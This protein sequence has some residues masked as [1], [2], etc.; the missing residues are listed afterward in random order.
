MYRLQ[1]KASS[2]IEHTSYQAV[3]NYYITELLIKKCV[4]SVG[5]VLAKEDTFASNNENG[6]RTG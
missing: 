3:I 4:T 2:R 5:K 6:D 1:R